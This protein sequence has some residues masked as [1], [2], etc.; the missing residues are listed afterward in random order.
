MPSTFKFHVNV[1]KEMMDIPFR[2]KEGRW[3]PPLSLY[4]KIVQVRIIDWLY[5]IIRVSKAVLGNE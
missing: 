5:A 2:E 4:G 1:S 3:L